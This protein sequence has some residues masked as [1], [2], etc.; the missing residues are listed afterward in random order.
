MDKLGVCSERLKVLMST[1][2]SGKLNEIKDLKL[3]NSKYGILYSRT[4]ECDRIQDVVD[5]YLAKY[6]RILRWEG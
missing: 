4:K 1:I 3:L 6:E 2:I 5:Q